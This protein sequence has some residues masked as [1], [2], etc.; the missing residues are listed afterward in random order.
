M[1]LALALGTFV[2]TMLGGLLA[3][4]QRHQLALIMSVASGILVTAALLDIF[5]EALDLSGEAGFH[6]VLVGALAGFVT[7]FALDW[8]VHLHA[9]GHLHPHQ[10]G[11]RIH[12]HRHGL[13]DE[14]GPEGSAELDEGARPSAFGALA[15]LGLTIHSFLDGFAIGTA[16]QASERAGLVVALAVLTH[17]FG[18]GVSTVGVVLGQ[19]GRT[20][21]AFGWLLADALAPVL[22]AAVPLVLT[23]SP[24]LLGPLLGFFA[25]SFLF[26]G[27]SHLLPEAG[28]ECSESARFGSFLA[29]MLVIVLATQVFAA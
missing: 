26:I 4:R 29:G 1:A 25:G 2:S 24:S 12:E 8:L 11:P 16:F 6:R 13:E 10:P 23:I 18:D 22:G 5:P 21:T 9:A 20:R 14:P 17:D 7:F 28:G 27:A 15:A 19:R 3:L